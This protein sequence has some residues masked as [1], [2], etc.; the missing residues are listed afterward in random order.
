MKI[1]TTS[2]EFANLVGGVLITSEKPK[3]IIRDSREIKILGDI[4]KKIDL[5]LD[6]IKLDFSEVLS[7]LDGEIKI[8]ISPNCPVCP[9]VVREICSIPI[10]KLEI[11]DVLDYPEIANEFGIMAI[12][13]VVIGKVKLVGRVNR[14]DV[15]EWIKKSHDRKE[16]FA[17][18]LKDGEVEEVVRNVEKEGDANILVDLLTYKDF[19]VRLGAMVAIEDLSKRRPEIVEDVKDEMRNL[20]DHEDERIRQDVAMLLGDI[21]DESDMSFLENLLDE[22]GDV[23]ES[24][25]EALE[26][27]RRRSRKSKSDFFKK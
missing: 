5:F 25:K 6:I 7:V 21:G 14:K 13:T 23:G 22:K 16:Y 3:T 8:F 4:S 27:I 20:L 2:K 11:I 15:L 1:E 19:I 18:L 10:R 12:P 24:A 17:K 9:Y 26:V